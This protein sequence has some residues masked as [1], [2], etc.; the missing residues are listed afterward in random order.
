M[1]KISSSCGLCLD[2]DTCY[3]KKKEGKVA[4]NV[5]SR[6]RQKTP[7][8]FFLFASPPPL[9]PLRL[10]PLLL[11][12]TQERDRGH[13]DQWEKGRLLS[14]LDGAL[15]GKTDEDSTDEDGKTKRKK[16]EE[17]AVDG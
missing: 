1:K 12:R 2:Q 7:L 3:K 5:H 4:A 14:L 6:D 11:R 9:S 15:V 8:S 17:E 13:P 16:D 10:L